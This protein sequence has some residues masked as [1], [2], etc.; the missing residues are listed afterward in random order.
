M[1]I[2]VVV[3]PNSRRESVQPQ[4]DGSYKVALNAPPHEGL[5]NERL[6]ELLAAFFKVPP[7][8][9]D[10]VRG[11]ASRHKWIEVRPRDQ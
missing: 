10:I 1:K 3:K 8:S 7:S 9:I 5:A 11:H 4:A 2:H 6:I